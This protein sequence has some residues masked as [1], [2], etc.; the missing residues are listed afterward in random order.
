MMDLLVASSP[1]I[2]LIYMM[3]KKNSVPSHVALPVAAALVYGIKLIYFGHDPNLINATVVNGLL[4]AWTP[5]LIIWGAIFLFKTMEHSGGMDIIRAWLNTI[6]DNR[7]AQLMIIGWAF[8]FLIEGASGFG[9]PPA[10]AA[11]I[12]VGLGFD[13]LKVAILCLMMNT[14]PVSFGAV[15]TPTWFGF[16]GLGLADDVIRDISFVSA[17][18]NAMAALFIPLIALR[19][20]VPWREI[21]QS[22]AFIYLSILSCVLPY[23]LL[24]RF[25]YEFPAI[26]GG[27]FGLLASILLSKKGIG[28]A[29]ASEQFID[30]APSMPIKKL[31]TALFPLWGTIVVLMVTRIEELG[32]KGFLTDATPVFQTALGSFADF[33]VSSSLVV[34]LKNIFGTDI[35]WAF[36]SLYVPALI[37]FFFISVISFGLYKLSKPVMRQIAS[38]SY[39]RMKKP[40]LALLGALVMVKLM[41]VGGNQSSVMLIGRSFAEAIGDRWQFFASYLGAV[42]SFFSGSATISNLTFGGI[43]DAIAQDLRLDRTIVLSAQSAGGAMGNMV[44]INNIVAVCSI[45]GLLNKEGAILKKTVLPALLYG[46]IVAFVGYV[47]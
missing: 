9:T 27:M 8:A 40:I 44:S 39:D 33:T 45:L 26:V 2:V 22:L 32:L 30:K 38:E 36:Q 47:F 20:V 37:P 42:G 43:Q 10:L 35:I 4:T 13:P 29:P 21:K 7:I 28:L 5:I 23:V 24:A 41:M 19:F 14:V 12:L 18:M 3:T 11:P 46:I 16:G 15:G 6:S 25:N 1:I 34:G 17:M 31:I